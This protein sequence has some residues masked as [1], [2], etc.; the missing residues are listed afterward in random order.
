MQPMQSLNMAQ[1]ELQWRPGDW[2]DAIHGHMAA[3]TTFYQRVQTNQ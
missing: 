3:L 2:F 1:K